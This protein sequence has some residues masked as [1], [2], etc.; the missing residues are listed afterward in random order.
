MHSEKQFMTKETIR[1][2]FENYVLEIFPKIFWKAFKDK[3]DAKGCQP[4]PLLK[5][6]L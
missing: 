6:G 4:A 5:K 2:C 1:R 3:P